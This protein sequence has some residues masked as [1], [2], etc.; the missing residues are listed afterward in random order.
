MDILFNEQIKYELGI[1]N[2]DTQY[3]K[4]DN[5]VAYCKFYDTVSGRTWYVIEAEKDR[6]NIVFHGLI[7]DG[8]R[9]ESAYFYLSNLSTS[10]S[11]TPEVI[12][13]L[14]FKPATL[15]EIKRRTVRTF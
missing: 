4:G 9:I 10:K 15:S 7:I 11:D 6:N 13:D 1:P 12:R 5:A 3:E 14:S 2:I 8:V